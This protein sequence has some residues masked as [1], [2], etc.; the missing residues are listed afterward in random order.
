[1]KYS[2]GISSGGDLNKKAA[3]FNGDGLINILDSIAVL[4]EISA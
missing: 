4:S 1:M 3:D 2:S